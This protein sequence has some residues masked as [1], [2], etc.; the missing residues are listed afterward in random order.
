MYLAEKVEI[1]L[2]NLD[3][4][5]GYGNTCITHMMNLKETLFDYN[6]EEADTGIVLHVLDVSERDPFTDLVISYSDTDV[7]LILLFYYED[8]CP[9]CIF[10]TRNNEFKLQTI[11]E[12]HAKLCS[13]F[14][15]FPDVT[16]QANLMVIQS[17]H[18][19]GHVD[20][21]MSLSWKHFEHLAKISPRL[22]MMGLRTL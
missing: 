5:V 18:A 2:N 13:V 9:S 21:P 14:I 8:L 6:Q 20:H 11:H 7:L 1:Y 17:F 15:R 22:L 10:K 12:K 19:E 4:V 16:K 3:Y